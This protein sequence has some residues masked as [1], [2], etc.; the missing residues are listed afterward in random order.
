MD[1]RTFLFGCIAGIFIVIGSFVAVSEIAG[2]KWQPVPTV[3][4]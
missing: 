3:S 2:I 4:P 1:P